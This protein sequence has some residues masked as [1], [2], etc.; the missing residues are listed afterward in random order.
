MPGG[1]VLRRR[2]RGVRALPRGDVPATPGERRGG[3]VSALPGWEVQRRGRERGVLPVLPGG[4]PRVRRVLEK[5]Q[6]VLR[7]TRLVQRREGPGEGPGRRLRQLPAEAVPPRVQQVR[8]RE[9]VH[10]RDV[11][12]HGG[13]NRAGISGR[14]MTREK[15][16]EID[17]AS[18]DVAPRSSDTSSSRVQVASTRTIARTNATK[19]LKRPPPEKSSSRLTRPL[20]G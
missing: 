10:E 14:R 9:L 8:R 19:A 5:G 18:R 3:V 2:R 6:R 15:R 11:R 17:R 16:S 4:E 1:N 20:A 7:H 12:V 13:R